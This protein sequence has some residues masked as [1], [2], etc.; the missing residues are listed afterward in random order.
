MKAV[1]I[2]LSLA[3]LVLSF[4]HVNAQ[5]SLHIN[6]LKIANS[7]EDLVDVG[8]SLL[9]GHHST[10]IDTVR[11]KVGKL[12]ISALPV[13]GYT[14]QTG[15]A[16]VVT[17]DFAFYTSEHDQANLSSVLTSIAYTQYQQVILP[18][19]ANIWTRGN[20]YNILT[21]WRYLRYP[22]ITY[23]LGGNSSA[24]SGYNIYYG[25][26]R[27]H[28]AILRTIA[29]DFYLG[30]GFDADY[31]WNIQEVD[32]PAAKPTD[33][34]RYGLTRTEAAAGF[35][36]HVLFDDRRNQIN[37]EKGNYLS[38]IYRPSLTSLG[39]DNNFQTLLLDLRKYI[40]FPS[41]THN[42]LAFWSYDWL[43]LGSGNPPYLLLP[44]TGWDEYSNTGRGYIQGRYRSKNML[45]LES[46]YRFGITTNGLLGGVV[47]ANAESFSDMLT[48]HYTYINP[49]YG[50]GIR[51]SLNKF[52]R[53]NIAVD[54]G[55]GIHGS[56]GFFVNL[57]EVF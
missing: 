54:Y 17:S 42:V 43:T 8:R 53:T 14:L 16:G 19:Q 18:V 2:Y 57:G 11:Q 45:Y 50:G 52:S 6:H 56:G 29:R 1:K 37:P 46:E 4:L 49:G 22:S 24:D 7:Q 28:Q 33:F 36:L 31:F 9:K 15:F 12:H 5:D 48:G 34:E 55:W 23:G 21:D 10:R 35:S 30:L 26:L 27:L 47:F 39:S 41:N 25:Y 40:T 13:A 44:S 51:I 32:P 3:L 38:L 20:K